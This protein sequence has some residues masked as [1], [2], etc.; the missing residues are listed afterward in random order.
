MIDY[1][2]KNKSAG[3]SS[4]VLEVELP[5]SLNI[6]SPKSNSPSVADKGKRKMVSESES[7]KLKP[8]RRMTRSQVVDALVE[9]STSAPLQ[10]KKNGDAMRSS[11]KSPKARKVVQKST[12]QVKVSSKS[13]AKKVKGIPKSLTFRNEDAKLHW[14][15]IIGRSFIREHNLRPTYVSEYRILELFESVGLSKTTL[16]VCPYV[17]KVVL[18]FYANLSTEIEDVTSKDVFLAYVCGLMFSFSPHEINN[19]IKFVSPREHIIS[20]DLNIL[21]KELIGGQITV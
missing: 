3:T 8:T 19:Y 9:L 13:S 1:Q 7:D 12:P 17:K 4:N 15:G 14:D 16:N 11:V 20:I 21:I 10:A 5:V 18:E 6:E 2:R